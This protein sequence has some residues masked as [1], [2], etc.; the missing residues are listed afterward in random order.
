M[1]DFDPI[2][3]VNFIIFLISLLAG[4]SAFIAAGTLKKS[5][6]TAF[7]V[8]STLIVPCTFVILVSSLIDMKNG[9]RLF[10]SRERSEEYY[11]AR[12]DLYKL[13]IGYFSIAV[14]FEQI[15]LS[16]WSI[17]VCGKT[18]SASG[19]SGDENRDTVAVTENSGGSQFR[20]AQHSEYPMQRLSQQTRQ[21]RG[22]NDG[23]YET[24]DDR[25]KS[26]MPEN[27][28]TLVHRIGTSRSEAARSC[29][30][31]LDTPTPP[32]AKRRERRRQQSSAYKSV[33]G[34]IRL[35]SGEKA[36]GMGRHWVE[37]DLPADRDA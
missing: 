28:R 5:A 24:L 30:H 25:R 22:P 8:L 29:K 36:T 18:L 26:S 21:G 14:Y 33:L 11:Y 16:I 27:Y 4:L 13:D 19:T 2:A 23:T 37:W 10:Y 32:F 7:L 9:D 3:M 12:R 6:V 35:S 15:G 34:L 20:A 1:E 17:V 31:I